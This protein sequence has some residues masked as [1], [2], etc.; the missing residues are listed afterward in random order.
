MDVT[1]HIQVITILHWNR[2]A[3]TDFFFKGEI[4]IQINIFHPASV[5]CMQTTGNDLTYH[6]PACTSSYSSAS[7]T[8]LPVDNVNGP[9]L[10]WI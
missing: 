4:S 3:A 2:F 1:V 10:T 6:C 7:V 8:S 5:A 9:S